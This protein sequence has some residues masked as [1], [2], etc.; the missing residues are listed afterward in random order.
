MSI[1]EAHKSRTENLYN[2]RDKNHDTTTNMLRVIYLFLLTI[3][4]SISDDKSFNP[5]SIT[6][7]EV[8]AE[9]KARTVK[10]E[11]GVVSGEK[12]WDGDFYQF[13]GIPYASVP[14]G[15]DR[16]KVSEDVYSRK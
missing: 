9:V 3:S 1:I 5:E 7:T 15:R 10:I 4:Y 13:Y 12:Y 8:K 16:F 14:K 6:P 2:I 11:D